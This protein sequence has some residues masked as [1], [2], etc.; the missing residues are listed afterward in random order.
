M[1]S[2]LNIL[3]QIYDLYDNFTENIDSACKKGCSHCCTCNVTV[4][5]I[6]AY[7]IIHYPVK[8]DQSNLL[9]GL[10]DLSGLSGLPGLSGSKKRFLPKVTTNQ[11]AEF[12]ID[13]GEI[14]EEE[15]RAEWGKCAFLSNDICSIYE[16]RPF[17]CRCMI[18]EKD[19]GKQGFASVK[20]FI[21]TVN[22]VFQQYIEHMDQNGY[23]GNIADVLA[24]L[25]KSAKRAGYTQNSLK[26]DDDLL[27]S[28]QKIKYLMIPPEDRAKIMPL[29]TQLIGLC[30]S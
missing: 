19:C 4:T 22:N 23:L 5:T 18:S 1:L 12:C 2:K 13:G 14:P 3:N 7:K 6:E 17:A 26:S 9:S 11:F 8:K 20:P 15:N 29:L 24:L 10:S 25:S 28:N 27:I 30:S 21:L 16:L